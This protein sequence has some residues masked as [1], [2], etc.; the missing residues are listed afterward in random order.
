MTGELD[1]E[2]RPTCWDRWAGWSWKVVSPCRLTGLVLTLM[3]S[4]RFVWIQMSSDIFRFR[5]EWKRWIEMDSDRLRWNQID[6]D[7]F[8]WFQMDWDWLRWDGHPGRQC[9]DDGF[10]SL[11][12]ATTLDS[13]SHPQVVLHQSSI[14]HYCKRTRPLQIFPLQREHTFWESLWAWSLWGDH[15]CLWAR[16]WSA[17]P[18]NPQFF[19]VLLVGE[20]F[21]KPVILYYIWHPNSQLMAAGDKTEIGENGINLSGG[22]KQRVALARYN[23]KQLFWLDDIMRTKALLSSG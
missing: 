7:G 20:N 13:E 22:Q 3:T 23:K 21:T 8:K 4:E 2:P 11:P 6:W 5:F 1:S 17:G 9:K 14:K 18:T 10:K 15:S 16:A 12:C 19:L